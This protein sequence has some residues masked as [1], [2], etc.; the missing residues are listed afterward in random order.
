MAA[1]SPSSTQDSNQ[2]SSR[3]RTTL[4]YRSFGISFSQ[5]SIG[6]ALFK[7]TLSAFPY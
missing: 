7:S 5:L 4:P 6:N 1:S 2:R 3:R